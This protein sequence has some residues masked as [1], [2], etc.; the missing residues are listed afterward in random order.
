[1][2]TDKFEILVLGASYGLLPGIKLAMAGHRVTFVARP[3]EVQRLSGSPMTVRIP[4]RRSTDHIVLTT[5][6]EPQASASA[7]SLRIPEDVDASTADFAILAMQEPHFAAPEI[8]ALLARIGKA[9][10]PCLSIMNLPPPP[11]VKRI[12]IGSAAALEGVY[13]NEHVWDPIDPNLLSVASPD[14]QAVRMNPASPGDLT[15]TLASN[16]KAS[17][18]GSHAAQ[19]TLESLASDFSRLKV[20]HRGEEIRP[21]VAL[22][23]QKSLFAPLAKWPMVLTGNFRCLTDQGLR[24]ISEAVHDDL[25]ESREIY[26]WVYGVARESGAAISDMVLFDDYARAAKALDRPSSVARSVMAGA[27]AVERLDKLVGNLGR[28]RGL[29]NQKIARISEDVDRRLVSNQIA[30]NVTP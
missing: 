9:G 21:P 8:A 28:L 10:C 3:E 5:S 20:P 19:R 18:F 1:M 26:E 15:V 30:L 12:G 4:L 23:A 11:Y 13:T 24:T 14:P 27:T 22:L 7:P 6:A 17:S 16:F 25:D 29:T 2:P